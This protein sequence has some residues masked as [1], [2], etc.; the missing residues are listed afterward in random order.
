MPQEQKE[1]EACKHCG[2]T[3]CGCDE[4]IKDAYVAGYETGH[5]DTVES[6]YGSSEDLAEDY[7]K[8]L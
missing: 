1:W 3:M 5:N 6:C 2:A 4:L 7:L 8:D